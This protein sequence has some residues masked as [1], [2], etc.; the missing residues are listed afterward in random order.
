MRPSSPAGSKHTIGQ[1]LLMRFLLAFLLAATGSNFLPSTRTASPVVCWAAPD[2]ADGNASDAAAGS[3]ALPSEVASC[4]TSSP[5]PVRTCPDPPVLRVSYVSRGSVDCGGALTPGQADMAPLVRVVAGPGETA[6]DPGELYALVLVDT[7]IGADALGFDS[8]RPILHYGAVNIPG[9]SLLA[10][11]SLDR[12]DASDVFAS[13]RGPSGISVSV[14]DPRFEDPAGPG[15][16][17]NGN[18]LS[19]YEFFLGAQAD[20]AE[21][22]EVPTELDGVS[23]LGFDYEAFFDETVG[24]GFENVT[25]RTH[26]VAGSCVRD[27]VA[28]VRE[29]DEDETETETVPGGDSEAPSPPPVSLAT[30]GNLPQA[31]TA[32]TEGGPTAT[33]DP[34]S[35]PTASATPIVGKTETDPVPP[36]AAT[37]G[38]TG[39]THVGTVLSAAAGVVCVALSCLPW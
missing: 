19:V 20:G 8:D 14:T 18:G 26:F 16:E 4:E 25:V 15:S 3:S 10:G 36:A 28:T 37:S 5:A 9:S 35:L 23:I 30:G 29:D 27:P 11:I 24:I 32:T 39:H 12:S 6:I 21:P 7:T 1:A 31:A 2:G 38:A 34:E 13:Y 22:V 17:S 33:K